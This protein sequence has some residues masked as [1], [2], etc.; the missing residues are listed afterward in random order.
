M[1]GDDEPNA[2]STP[3]LLEGDPSHA[4]GENVHTLFM[5]VFL[6]VMEIEEC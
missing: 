3:I 1:F 4:T 5:F 2:S 6:K